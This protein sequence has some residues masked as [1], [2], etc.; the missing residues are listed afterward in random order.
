MGTRAPR[1]IDLS[2]ARTG[3]RTTCEN[4]PFRPGL[5]RTAVVFVDRRRPRPRR[6]AAA[7]SDT[8][9]PRRERG[10][11]GAAAGNGGATPERR[12]SAQ[13]RPAVRSVS[14]ASAWSLLRKAAADG[15]R[16]PASNRRRRSVTR[17]IGRPPAKAELAACD[18]RGADGVRAGVCVGSTV[19]PT[20]GHEPHFRVYF[21]RFRAENRRKTRKKKKSRSARSFLIKIFPGRSRISDVKRRR[22][23][24]SPLAYL[25]RTESDGR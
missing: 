15:R 5:C 8:V 17:S 18:G 21:F 1:T 10:K 20:L 3:N 11:P 22:N 25:R 12:R 13:T 16:R 4:F 2:S 9:G 7:S 6:A 23:V 14:I 24:L 19:G